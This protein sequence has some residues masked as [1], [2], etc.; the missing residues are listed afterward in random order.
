MW[1]QLRS[2]RMLNWGKGRQCVIF[3]HKKYEEDRNKT[4]DIGMSWRWVWG[5]KKRGQEGG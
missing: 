4:Q 3:H 2:L 5:T 1:G